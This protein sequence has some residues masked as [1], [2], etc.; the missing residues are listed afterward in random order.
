MRRFEGALFN[1]EREDRGRTAFSIVTKVHE[2]QRYGNENEG[3]QR[4]T[5]L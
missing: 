1:M 4:P 2:R 3:D 5:T